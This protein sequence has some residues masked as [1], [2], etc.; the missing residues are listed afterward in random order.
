MMMTT[1]AQAPMTDN[2]QHER[3][4][5]NVDVQV[6]LDDD[7][8]AGSTR[9]LSIGGMRLEMGADGPTMSTG[10]LIE[11]AFRLPQLDNEIRVP[12]RVRWVDRVDSR[13][14]GLQFLRGLRAVEV[15]AIDRMRRAG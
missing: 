5:V 9:D 2:R 7:S 11:V 14:G 13:V 10:M 12:A 6:V 3:H 4:D 15:W 1:S 8:F